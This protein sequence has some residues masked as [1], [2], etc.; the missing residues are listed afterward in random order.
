MGER[1]EQGER[2]AATRKMDAAKAVVE[3]L[4]AEH[5]EIV[6]G[7]VGT[8]VLAIFDA[9]AHAP[10]IRHVVAKHENNA[11]FMAGMYGYLTGRP[12]VVLVTAGPGATN[13]I[14]GVAQAYNQSMPVVHICGGVPL[15]SG[16]AAHHGVDSEDFLNRMF[17]PI[18]KWSVRI[19]RAEDIPSVLAR[20]FSLAVSGRPGPVNVEIPRDIGEARNADMPVYMSAA[21]TKTTPQEADITRAYWMLAKSKRPMICAGRG[22]LVHRAESELLALAETVSAPVLETGDA[23]G[24]MPASHPLSLGLLPQRGPDQFAAK[25]L[26]ESDCL[27]CLGMRSN[28]TLTK[29]LKS[30]LPKETFLVALDEPRT[31]QPTEGMFVVGCDTRLFLDSILSNAAAALA[32][33]V[34]LS[35]QARIAQE[36]A[37]KKK[38]LARKLALERMLP[39]GLPLSTDGSRLHFG[40]VIEELFSHLEK[41]AIVVAGVGHHAFWAKS[42]ARIENRESFITEGFWGT[43]GS[44]LAGG[45]AAKLVYP[46][47]RVIVI[48][49]DGSLLMSASDVVTSVEVGANLLVVVLNDSRYATITA[50]QRDLFGR[51]FGDRLGTTDF[52]KF[53]E[54]FGATG[55]RIES[56]GRLKETV[57]R[58]LELSAHNSVILDAVC[59]DELYGRVSVVKRNLDKLKKRMTNA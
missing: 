8:H 1:M 57:K 46:D 21:P 35:L 4:L 48:T 30:R 19:E 49:G 32:R 50:M 53:A 9:L 23:T 16:N 13:S 34:D 56:A 39:V 5:V 22:V 52:A 42:F 10:E 55:L 24:V 47:R 41:D 27:L 6:F 54:S 44:E 59:S 12:G 38:R 3:S 33:P 36:K 31:L 14:S 45:I 18:T 7:T 28:S 15:G 2:M 29:T 43:M 40:L 25:L 17:S 26:E 11:A 58:A 20:A 37:G 51:P